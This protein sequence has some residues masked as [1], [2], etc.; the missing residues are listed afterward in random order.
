MNGALISSLDGTDLKN[1]FGIVIVKPVIRLTAESI[2]VLPVGN[3]WTSGH[4]VKHHSWA[5]VIVLF[6]VVT[7]NEIAVALP[8][9][10]ETMLG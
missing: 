2:K 5:R 4:S 7:Q 9:R 8:E 6:H 1:V 10:Q 3:P